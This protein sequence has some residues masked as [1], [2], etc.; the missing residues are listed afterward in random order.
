MVKAAIFD[1]DGL[2]IDSEPLWQEA[3][4]AGFAEVGLDLTVDMCRRTMGMRADEMVNYWFRRH[5]WT[6]PT[7]AEVKQAILSRLAALIETRA[8]PMPGVF[9][10]VALLQRAGIPMIIASSSPQSVI[11]TVIDSFGLR[12]AIPAGLSAENEPLGKP[13]PGVFLRAAAQLGVAARDCLVFEDS[14]TGVIAAKAACMTTIAVPDPA[15]FARPEYSIADHRLRS[16]TEFDLAL[17]GAPD[18]IPA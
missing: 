8:A 4:I 11:D 10:T 18:A 16:L 14:I 9:D 1:M 2:L 7:E 17:I 6:G 12:Q 3:E 5:P 13:H 15:L